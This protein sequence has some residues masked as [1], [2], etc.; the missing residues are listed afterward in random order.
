MGSLQNTIRRTLDK[1]GNVKSQTDGQLLA[2][3]VAS[4]EPAP[5][6]E[7]VR[8]H[9]PMV[10]RI[11]Q[12]I[13]N[14]AQDA[15]DA[16][17]ATFI[18]LIR[19]AHA[20]A[21]QDSVASWLHGVASRVARHARKV[22]SRRHERERST[23]ETRLDDDRRPAAPADRSLVLDEELNR[24]P[25]KYR[26]AIVLC[27]F[28][29][30]SNEEA[31]RLLHCSLSAMKV[32]L[33]RARDMLHARLSRRGVTLSAAGLGAILTNASASAAVPARLATATTRAVLTHATGQAGVSATAAHAFANAALKAMA[34]RKVRIA[35]GVLLLLGLIGGLAVRSAFRS[36]N[37]GAGTQTQA[38]EA[39]APANAPVQNFGKV[40]LASGN[41]ATF[42][43]AFSQPGPHIGGSLGGSFS[44]IRVLNAA[45]G[46]ARDFVGGFSVTGNAQQMILTSTPGN[47]FMLTMVGAGPHGP[48]KQVGKPVPIRVTVVVN[49]KPTRA[50][51]P[52]SSQWPEGS[53]CNAATMTFKAVDASTG[54]PIIA[55]DALTGYTV[56]LP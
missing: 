52:P 42:G 53:T 47:A 45:T 31:A 13:L 19:R 39:F 25:E 54:A 2:W 4:Q 41:D 3:F 51:F 15:E 12:R 48:G 1:L 20:I 35:V 10:L 14:H 36:T 16:F 17:Q 29:G 44:G 28:E 7:L 11:C 27:Y 30:K 37:P 46:T 50:P 6:E 18:V 32:R 9:G 40:V 33:F 21:K 55:T 24:L 23:T 56:A 26:A 43:L 49:L 38:A 5:V 8:R 34:P 22:A